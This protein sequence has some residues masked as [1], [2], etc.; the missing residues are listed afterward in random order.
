MDGEES[1]RRASVLTLDDVFLQADNFRLE[2]VL[3]LQ[4]VPT[5][6]LEKL[7]FVLEVRLQSCG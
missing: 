6:V 3:N 2:I 5:H 4:L 1:L 7:A